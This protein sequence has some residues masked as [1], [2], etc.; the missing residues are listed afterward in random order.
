MPT[1]VRISDEVNAAYKARA[2]ARG[3]KGWSVTKEIDETLRVAAG[4]TDPPASAPAPER[5]ARRQPPAPRTAATRPTSE[6][7]PSA[8]RPVRR[9]PAETEPSR[10]QHPPGRRIGKL[11]MVCGGTVG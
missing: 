6:R 3:I 9:P 2:E 1:T 5:P 10:C 11:C 7:N 8:A 4:L